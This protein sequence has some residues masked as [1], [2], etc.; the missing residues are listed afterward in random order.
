MQNQE[1]KHHLEFIKKSIKC[2]EYGSKNKI[3][4]PF[5]AVITKDGIQISEGWNTVT[6]D[7]D[8]TAHAEVNAI[9]KA[10]KALNTFNL[11]SCCIYV[12][13]EPCPMCLSAIYWARID[14]IFFAGT[15]QDVEKIGFDDSFIYDEI[16]KPLDKRK[17][18][19]VQIGRELCFDTFDK[20]TQLKDKIEY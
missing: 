18:P 19:M 14:K 1:K 13:A 11:N 5:G 3:G 17:I 10:C 20:W 4:G 6:T 7:N 9:R 2:A 8:P 12:N 15:R 16:N